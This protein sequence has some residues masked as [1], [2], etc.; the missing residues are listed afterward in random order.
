MK[1]I[2]SIFM[3]VAVLGSVMVGCGAKEEPKADAPA[4]GAPA[5]TPPAK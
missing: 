4:A 2:L 5:E 3:V 1:K